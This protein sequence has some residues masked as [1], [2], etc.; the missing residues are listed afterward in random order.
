M[1]EVVDREMFEMSSDR[2]FDVHHIGRKVDDFD[3]AVMAMERVD[4]YKY[5]VVRVFPPGLPSAVA[6]SFL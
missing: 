6:G 3:I 1:L 4:I 5:S 2:W